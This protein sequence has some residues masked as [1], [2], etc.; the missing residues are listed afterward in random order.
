VGPFLKGKRRID[1]RLGGDVY[2]LYIRMETTIQKWGN[3]LAIRIPAGV[4][5][6]I[7]VQEGDRVELNIDAKVLSIQAARPR[8]SL[9]SLVKQI[10]KSNVHGEPY[11][12]G[13]AGREA[14]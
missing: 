5:R 10:T 6:E 3:S 13:P 1:L 2:T 9:P 14:W 11:W 8:Y 7:A 4:A 12:G